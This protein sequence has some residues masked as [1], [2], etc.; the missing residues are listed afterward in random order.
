MDGKCIQKMELELCSEI[1]PPRLSLGCDKHQDI[2]TDILL[3]EKHHR[4]AEIYRDMNIDPTK[5]LGRDEKGDLVRKRGR[6]GGVGQLHAPA[7]TL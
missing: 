3:C 2:L 7:H 5:G 1:L 6:S 4:A